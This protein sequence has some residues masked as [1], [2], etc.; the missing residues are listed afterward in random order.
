MKQYLILSHIQPDP[1]ASVQIEVGACDVFKQR[2]EELLEE[3]L[4]RTG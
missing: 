4:E 3:S 2:V 1:E